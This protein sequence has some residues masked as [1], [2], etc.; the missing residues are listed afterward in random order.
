MKKIFFAAVAALA[1]VA[2]SG[3]KPNPNAY[4]IN[5]TVT[6]ADGETVYLIAQGDTL[7]STTVQNG[8][9]TFNGVAETSKEAKIFI[10]RQLNDGLFLEPGVI[11]HSYC[12]SPG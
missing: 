8:A 10:N 2:C 7:A 5:G 3:E 11:N 1:L 9:F 4:T 12:R 6:G